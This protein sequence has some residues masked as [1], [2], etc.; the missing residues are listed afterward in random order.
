[1]GSAI[2]KTLIRS[3]A[4]AIAT[5]FSVSIW[6]QSTEFSAEFNRLD[7]QEQ[8]RLRT[9]LAEPTPQNA[10]QKNLRGHFKAKE[11]A[12]L[13]LGDEAQYEIVLRDAVRVLPDP[14]YKNN[15]SRRLILKGEFD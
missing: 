9:I 6:A 13:K 12:A 14:V 10:S 11:A 8:Q 3:V 7:P 5:V 1:M 4:L 2:Y 15:L